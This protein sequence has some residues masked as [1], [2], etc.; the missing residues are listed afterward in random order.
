[1]TCFWGAQDAE[2]SL[3]PGAEFPQFIERLRNPWG[4]QEQHKQDYGGSTALDMLVI[5]IGG[6][7][8]EE[9]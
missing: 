8:I 5:Y 9:I 6:Q 7:A 2:G 3:S 4:E 1:M